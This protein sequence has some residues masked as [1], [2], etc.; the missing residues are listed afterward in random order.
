M[1]DSAAPTSRV[2]HL[3]LKGDFSELLPA[4]LD[5]QDG[6]GVRLRIPYLVGNFPERWFWS[7]L[8]QHI[9]SDG[10]VVPPEPSP[11][12]LDYFDNRGSVGLV[13]CRSAGGGSVM[14]GGFSA[15]SGIGELAANFAVEK[16]ARAANYAKIN[17]FRSEIDGLGHWLNLWA[18]R[19]T[20]TLPKDGSPMS[21]STTIDLPPDLRLASKLNLCATVR[22]TAPGSLEPEVRYTSTALLQTFSTKERDWTEHL[23]AHRAIRDLLRVAIWKPVAFRGHEATSDKERVALNEGDEPRSRWC[24]VKTAVTGVGDAVWGKNERP[25]FVF[26]DLKTAGIRKWLKFGE[27]NRRGLRPFLRLL[28]IR[29]GTIDEHL[30]QL[31]IAIEA[32]GYQ[33]FRDSGVS[34]KRA[35]SKTMEQRVRKIVAEV[36]TCIPSIPSTF[37][38]D[39]ADGYNAVKHANRPEPDPAVLFANYRLGVKIV[40]AWIAVRLGVPDGLIAERLR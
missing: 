11:A 6:G 21:V 24:E 9:G 40:R 26:A 5:E 8:G 34:E 32:F 22:G 16:A 7:D 14:F 38:E 19:T 18:H 15:S 35:D 13:G 17:G 2:G 31:G 1:A 28:D 33:A 30:A 4:T 10:K 20:I 25:L 23:Q 37:A 36:A 3:N 29:E 39:F 27:E 12:E